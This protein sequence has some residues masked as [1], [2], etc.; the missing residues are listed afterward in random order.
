HPDFAYAVGAY[1][2]FL[3]RTGRAPDAEPWYRRALAI[4]RKVHRGPHG[5]VG[6]ALDALAQVLVQLGRLDEAEP[7]F[8]DGVA[9]I[10][11]AYGADH[12]RLEIPL[13][14][15]G[16]LRIEQGDLDEAERLAGRSLR[17]AQDAYGESNPRIATALHDLAYVVDLQGRH[18][19]AR[20]HYERAIALAEEGSADP[21]DVTSKRLNLAML[22][23]RVGD[24]AEAIRGLALVVDQEETELIETLGFGTP[25]DRLR[26]LQMFGMT[27]GMAITLHLGHPEDARAAELA[28]ETVLR[29][30]G[31]LEALEA[32]LL[33]GLRGVEDAPLAT[34][35]QLYAE[36][37]ALRFERPSSRDG[38]VAWFQRRSDLAA[39]LRTVQRAMIERSSGYRE[40]TRS[41]TLNEVK[42]AVPSGRVLLEIVAYEPY[43]AKTSRFG[44]P[45]YAAYVLPFDGP[46]QV[47]DLGPTEPIDGLVE[48][49][50]AAILQQRDPTNEVEAL[51]ARIFAPFETT[52]RGMEHLYVAPDGLLNLVPFE[53]LTDQPVSYLTSGRELLV[54]APASVEAGPAWVVYDIDPDRAERPG[55]ETGRAPT[56]RVT[57]LPG[58]IDEGRQVARRLR[59][60]KTLRGAAATETA[61]RAI[62]RPSVLH[63]AAHGFFETNGLPWRAVTPLNRGLALPARPSSRRP[64][65]LE[66]PLF[67]SGLVLAG[68]N[69]P[70]AGTDNGRLTAAEFTGV[71]LRGTKLVV[72]SACHT[73]EGEIRNGDGVHGLRRGLVLA[74]ARTQVLSLWAVDD[75]ATAAWMKAF[76]K[77]FAKGRTA[78]ESLRAAQRAVRA[79][80]QWA[81]P[82]Y[83]AAF[84][85]SGDPDVQL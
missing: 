82:F 43:D 2:G 12:P 57:P 84:T 63:I 5:D 33:D 66:L 46:I 6:R 39:Q 51:S 67:Q 56:M 61:V 13:A 72:L 1:A 24:H 73:A 68:A 8:R 15:L 52:L 35:R 19:E 50:R 78:A 80:P 30:K 16:R 3:E 37:D 4:Q 17:V 25:E 77:S 79:R 36:M 32:N 74:G 41:V 71:D 26:R 29:R 48:R 45:R 60:S 62:E 20:A 76:Y 59:G 53:G 65:A 34:L 49:Y 85:L 14:N 21:R 54:T 10:E 83:W 55:V 58:T 64:Y 11:A 69:R 22:N 40:A 18:D 28:L 9:M 31:R 42:A 70:S 23:L 7:L 38:T 47:A 81:H 75:A 27:T 44:A